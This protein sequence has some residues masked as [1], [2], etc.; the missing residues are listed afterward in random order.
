M[1]SITFLLHAKRS[2]QT[3]NL[4]IISALFYTA[5]KYFL[6]IGIQAVIII[7]EA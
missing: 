4:L 5:G 6:D 7:L 1:I 2:G 3:L